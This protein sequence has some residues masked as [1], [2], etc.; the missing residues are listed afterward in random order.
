[1]RRFRRTVAA[2]LYPHV[3][4]REGESG[5]HVLAVEHAV[6]ANTVGSPIGR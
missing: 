2:S 5:E 4:E 1:M 6:L 3:T